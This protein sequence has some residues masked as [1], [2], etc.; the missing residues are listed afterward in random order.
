MAT[1]STSRMGFGLVVRHLEVGRNDQANDRIHRIGPLIEDVYVT[2]SVF[3]FLNV[4]HDSV[5]RLNF[6]RRFRLLNVDPGF[7][8]V[9]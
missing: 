3:A 2:D 4:K 8:L 9:P 7:L 5:E 6:C 1:T